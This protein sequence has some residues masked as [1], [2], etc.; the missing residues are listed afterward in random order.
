MSK[1]NLGDGQRENLVLKMELLRELGDMTRYTGHMIN[2]LAY[3]ERDFQLAIDNFVGNLID[4][5][6]IIAEIGNL[7]YEHS[8]GVQIREGA[9]LDNVTKIIRQ[10]LLM[11]YGTH[12]T[13]EDR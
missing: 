7:L 10:G 5:N 6:N 8:K 1:I 3:Y 9:D 11:V 13:K 2:Q 4:I 12:R